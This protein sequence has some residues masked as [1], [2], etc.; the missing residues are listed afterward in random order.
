MAADLDKDQ[1]NSREDLKPALFIESAGI[2]GAEKVV[3]D[4]YRLLS[5]QG[6]NTPVILKRTGWLSHALE[7]EGA[8]LHFIKGESKLSFLT[9]LRRTLKKIKPSIVHSH[10]LDSN[11]YASIACKSCGIR[12]L[13]TEH[14]DVH[15]SSE[16]SG[17]AKKLKIMKALGTE[18]NSVAKFSA[19]KLTEFGIP[20]SRISTIPNPININVQELK[21]DERAEIRSKYG[22]EDRSFIWIHVANFRPVK[23]QASLLEGFANSLAKGKD[24]AETVPQKLWLVGDGDLRGE[25]ESKAR[26][27]KIH[28]S[29]QFLG[30]KEEVGK[31][32]AASDGFVL[33]SLSE[34]MPMSLLEAGTHG[35]APICSRVGGIPEILSG[36]EPSEEEDRKE[37]SRR[38][39]MFDSG[40][41]ERLGELMHKLASDP[42][43]TKDLGQRFKKFVVENYSGEKVSKAYLKRYEEICR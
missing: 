1:K 5:S 2:G 13:A 36:S 7:H 40:N 17:L 38:G 10:S 34:A 20:E 14:G 9:N 25:L 35:L 19:E 43:Q 8:E 21:P 11:F 27:L 41:T 28:D 3:F 31:Y 30:F 15:H 24:L 32:L 23:D 42:E 29:V 16:R 18:F 22:A 39:Y 37:G 4:L 33:S 12:H 6:V 26:S